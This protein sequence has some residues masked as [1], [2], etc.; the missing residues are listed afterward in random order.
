MF[1]KEIEDY[2]NQYYRTSSVLSLLGKEL[3]WIDIYNHPYPVYKFKVSEIR[4]YEYDFGKQ[5]G[6]LLILT[7]MSLWNVKTYHDDLEKDITL[8][9]KELFFTY[10]QA[11]KLMYCSLKSRQTR[12][13]L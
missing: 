2:S 9:G 6:I 10:E 13:D 4:M 7:P 11:K 5:V 1:K 3:F 12:L 8:I